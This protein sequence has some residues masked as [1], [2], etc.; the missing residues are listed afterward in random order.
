[1]VNSH[2]YLVCLFSRPTHNNNLRV[3][4]KGYFATLQQTFAFSKK[5]TY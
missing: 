4:E 1:M 5:H 2:N 3:A